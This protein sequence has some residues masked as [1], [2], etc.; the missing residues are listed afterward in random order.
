M[1]PA[2]ISRFI[3]GLLLLALPCS[4]QQQIPAKSIAAIRSIDPADTDFSDLQSIRSA[5][6]DARIVL[7]GEQTHGEGSTYLA[8]TRLIKYL[9]EQLG[10]S[11]LAFESGFYDVA[12][13]WENT[14]HNST[15]KEE[16]PGS[17]FYMY[18]GS[19]QMFPLFDYIQSKVHQ[20][21]ELLVTG[22]ESQHSGEK[23]K[24]LLFPDFEKYLQNK[25][26]GLLGN[27]WEVFKKL[28][29]ATMASRAY[30]PTE[31]EK[32]IFF[33]K[34]TELKKGLSPDDV[35]PENHFIESGGFWYRVVASIESQAIRYWEIVKGNEMNPRDLQMAENLIWLA[36][37]AYP[38]KKIIVWAHNLH[39]AKGTSELKTENQGLNWFLSTFVPMGVTVHQHFGKAA[40]AIGFTGATGTFIDFND[41]KLQ[42]IAPLPKGSVESQLAQTGNKYSF[43]NYLPLKEQLG[44]P[45]PA[46]ILD[47]IHTTGIWPNILDGL[48]FIKQPTPVDR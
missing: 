23:A 25:N 39:I 38:G 24:T 44:K 8:K 36:D 15:F 46:M 21:D 19:K 13:I 5:I 47:Y 17:L 4:S 35:T 45:Q 26:P 30:R 18:A 28:S 42:T 27:D 32:K 9:H 33:T 20:P 43:T 29:I 11:V 3:T 10:F 37:K 2:R 14:Q 16:I 6:G 22:F 1:S 48:F 12:R 41:G 31:E 7:L 40:Y 34:L